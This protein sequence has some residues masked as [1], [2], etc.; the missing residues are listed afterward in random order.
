MILEMVRDLSVIQ[1][2]IL[3]LGSLSLEE[4]MEKGFILGRME[5]SMMVNGIKG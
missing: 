4:R 1:M 3:I 5:K 2:A